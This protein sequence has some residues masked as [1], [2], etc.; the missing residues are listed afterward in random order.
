M[1]RKEDTMKKN[2]FTVILAINV[3]LLCSCGQTSQEVEVSDGSMDVSEEQQSDYVVNIDDS[4]NTG[5]VIDDTKKTLS[6]EE[7]DFRNLKWGMTKDEVSYAQGTGYRE[8]S[9]NKMYY[10]RLREEGFPADAEYTF[11]DGKLVQGIFFISQNK[12]DEAVSVDDY[13]ELVESLRSRFGEP[14]I[15]NLVYSNPEDETEDKDAQLELVKAGKLQFR[16]GW[17]LDDTELRVVMFPEND[18][19]SIGLQY[20][21]AGVEIPVE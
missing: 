9:E 12:S 7:A 18:G 13:V 21:Q 15:A 10:T 11:K 14:Q 17:L 2:I 6:P 19:V 1:V 20:K 5:L 16:T 3:L 4:F 8:P